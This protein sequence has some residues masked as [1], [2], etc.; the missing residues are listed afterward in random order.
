MPDKPRDEDGHSN[1]IEHGKCNADSLVH[2]PLMEGDQ[3]HLGRVIFPRRASWMVKGA[4]KVATFVII[5]K[6]VVRSHPGTGR[7]ISMRL[8]EMPVNLTSAV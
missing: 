2:R 7:A 3:E 8:R 1:H 4:L 6:G 5:L